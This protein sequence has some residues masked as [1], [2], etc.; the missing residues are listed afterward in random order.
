MIRYQV[1]GV[2]IDE[3]IQSLQGYP[4]A[5]V[6][7]MTRAME[8]SV[9]AVEAAVKPLVPVGV[10]GRLRASIGS[11]VLAA[12]SQILGR[13]GSSLADEEYPAVMEFGR[14]PGKMPPV[15]ALFRWVHLKHITGTYSIKTRRRRGSA[16]SQ[17]DQDRQAAWMI[18][19]AIGRK[20]IKGR[21]YLERGFEQAK[22]QVEAFHARAVV[23]LVEELSG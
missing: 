22:P 2:G 12:G 11:G 7:H 19:R 17:A 3:A 14:K 23:D 20:G 21:H 16:T 15:E 5:R 13:V 18:A 4:A 6:K 1:K 10:S 8:Q 9:K